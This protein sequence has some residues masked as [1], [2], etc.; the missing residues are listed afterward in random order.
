MLL[1]C[2]GNRCAF[3]GCDQPLVNVRK[4][5]IGEACHIAAASPGG[6]RFD[7]GMTDEARRSCANL[8]LMCHAH[9]VEVDLHPNEFTAASI[10]L[11]KAQ[12]EKRTQRTPFQVADEVL[13]AAEAQL[14]GF[15]PGVRQRQEELLPEDVRPELDL[16]A[17]VSDL[18][19]KIEES[20][21]RIDDMNDEVSA[22]M[23]AL[24][25][26]LIHFLESI[27]YD[28]RKLRDVPYFENPLWH[29]RSG[30]IL[31]GIPNALLAGR[32]ALAVLEVRVLS[33]FLAR[34]PGDA[35]MDAKFLE[36]KERL[37]KLAATPIVD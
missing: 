36:A 32:V 11:F 12:H 16:D 23:F 34:T 17:T 26:E 2:S 18:S 14:S 22:A 3:P 15:W 7:S 33:N 6:P 1:V 21:K 30:E 8:V 37:A 9:H 10:H 28:A 25:D 20:F 27:G 19:T 5:F 31:Y 13:R 29:R 24:P 35:V 4:D